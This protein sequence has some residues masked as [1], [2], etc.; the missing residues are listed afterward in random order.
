[1]CV[2]V[3]VFRFIN[4]CRLLLRLSWSQLIVKSIKPASV[5][6]SVDFDQRLSDWKFLT[7][8]SKTFKEPTPFTHVKFKKN[9]KKK[10]PE[11]LNP[12]VS[13]VHYFTTL[14]YFKIHSGTFT[15]LPVAQVSLVAQY[16]EGEVRWVLRLTLDQKLLPPP[17][18]GRET[19]SGCDIKHQHAAVGSSVQRCAQ[20]L[21]PLCACCVPDLRETQR[22]RR[23]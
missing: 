9:K 10:Q 14:W 6:I 16:N 4:I 21:E 3:C 7:W 22:W 1:M 13:L 19:S 12:V 8:K 23:M 15:D 5:W 17:L 2:C 18:Q 11:P 20:R